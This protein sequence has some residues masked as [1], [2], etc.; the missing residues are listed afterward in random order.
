MWGLANPK[1][2]GQVSSLDI[3]VRVDAAI[4]SLKFIGQAGRLEAQIRFLCHSLE[5]EFHPFLS[6][7]PVF[8]LRAFN[9]AEA[10]PP[11]GGQSALLEDPG[12]TRP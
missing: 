7:K 12:R 5:A 1:C 6:G 2:A 10:H 3:Q 4:L 8:C 11:C 9:W